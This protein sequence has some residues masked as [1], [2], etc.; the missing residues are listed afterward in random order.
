MQSTTVQLA[1]G[2]TYTCTGIKVRCHD[3]NSAYAYFSDLHGK[4]RPIRS[5]AELRQ[6]IHRSG[7]TYEQLDEWFW[8][9]L[10]ESG[11]AGC[12]GEP[13]Y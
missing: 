12:T 13:E 2:E 9:D 4:E 11:W 7:L 6:A 3:I 8:D 5:K 1:S 10:F